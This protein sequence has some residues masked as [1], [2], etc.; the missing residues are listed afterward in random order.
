MPYGEALARQLI[1]GQ[2]YTELRFG[3]K[4]R[5]ACLPDSFGLTGALPQIIDHPRSRHGPRFH[6]EAQRSVGGLHVHG[7]VRPF[8]DAL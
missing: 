6:S 1:F 7:F 5:I 2:R 3:L 4:N 8:A